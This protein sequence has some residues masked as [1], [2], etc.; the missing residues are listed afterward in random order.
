MFNGQDNRNQV[1]LNAGSRINRQGSY[2]Q[3]KQECQG[4]ITR[5]HK[6]SNYE[7]PKYEGISSN[8]RNEQR[9]DTRTN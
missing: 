9:M 5:N 2:H 4:R 8:Y 1:Y 6:E 3:Y 7:I